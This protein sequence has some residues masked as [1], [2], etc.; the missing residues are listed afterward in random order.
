VLERIAA[1]LA[2]SGELERL[3]NPALASPQTLEL[4]DKVLASDQTQRALGHVAS[5]PE[6]RDAVARQTTGLAEEV[7]GGVR[8]SAARLDDRAEQIVRRP[9]RTERHGRRRRR[10]GDRARPMKKLGHHVLGLAR[11][12]I[13]STVGRAACG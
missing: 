13:R 6:L 12:G 11:A 4:T 1:E 9:A 10:L 3:V 2:A 7:V 8:V 5:S